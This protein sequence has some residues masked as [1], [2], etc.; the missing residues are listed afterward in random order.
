MNFEINKSVSERIGLGIPRN[1]PTPEEWD[2]GSEF[3]NSDGVA[4]NCL[5]WNFLAAAVAVLKTFPA[6]IAMV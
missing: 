4:E 2:T 6:L 5:R 1:V 3:G